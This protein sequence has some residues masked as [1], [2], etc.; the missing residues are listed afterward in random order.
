MHSMAHSL[1]FTLDPNGRVEASLDG[2]IDL[3]ARFRAVTDVKRPTE[4]PVLRVR[5][6]VR[7][8]L[9]KEAGAGTQL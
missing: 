9:Y 5:V 4:K 6:R 8:V 3:D 1:S 7:E 2:T